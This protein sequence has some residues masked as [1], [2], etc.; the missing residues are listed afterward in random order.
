MEDRRKKLRSELYFWIVVVVWL[1]VGIV[2]WVIVK[3][4]FDFLVIIFFAVFLPLA[5]FGLF[6]RL[7]SILLD[8][9]RHPAEIEG[10]VL[11]KR[12]VGGVMGEVFYYLRI[13][14]LGFDVECGDKDEWDMVNKGDRVRV[15][16]HSHRKLI[17]SITVL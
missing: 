7:R 13:D 17:E 3:P 12:W 4:D 14:T 11:D 1:V 8:L 10:L 16:Y 9:R 2:L 15:T 6:W 5:F